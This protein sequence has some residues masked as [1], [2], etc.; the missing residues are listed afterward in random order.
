MKKIKSSESSWSFWICVQFLQ[1]IIPADNCVVKALLYKYTWNRF[2]CHYSK[3]VGL[4]SSL[5]CFTVIGQ[6]AFLP[7]F[8]LSLTALTIPF[9]LP[10][11]LL[12]MNIWTSDEYLLNP[13]MIWQLFTHNSSVGGQE[14]CKD[15]YCGD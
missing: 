3:F 5:N 6:P 11:F 1:F 14:L 12:H 15:L 2:Y 7:L 13:L 9:S 10:E 8:Q 4:S